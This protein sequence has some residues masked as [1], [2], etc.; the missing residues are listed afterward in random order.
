LFD[1]NERALINIKGFNPLLNSFELL[2]QVKQLKESHYNFDIWK[3]ELIEYG[4][5][6]KEVEFMEANKNEAL[7]DVRA[8]R[9]ELKEQFLSDVRSDIKKFIPTIYKH[10]KNNNLKHYLFNSVNAEDI[11]LSD[12]DKQLLFSNFDKIESYLFEVMTLA[13][14]TK[15][16]FESTAIVY[17][18]NDVYKDFNT[19]HKQLTF[20]ELEQRDAVNQ[21]ESI[22]KNKIEKIKRVFDGKHKV[23][24]EELIEIL[25]KQLNYK[26]SSVT[27][28]ALKN[29]IN[30][31]F[32][33]QYNKK[34][35]KF[36]LNLVKKEG[37]FLNSFYIEQKPNKVTDKINDSKGERVKN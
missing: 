27:N 30:G 22:T 31:V 37:T 16:T 21:K 25:R 18:A 3:A 29:Q 15:Q 12:L 11:E 34:N 2:H 14:L 1:W 24:K 5:K 19:V 6:F 17:F 33:I 8:K 23:S 4:I 10:S 7:K 20:L 35:K 28:S 26:L 13:N 32:D 9:K 36:T